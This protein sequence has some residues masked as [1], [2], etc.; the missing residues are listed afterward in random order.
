MSSSRVSKHKKQSKSKHTADYSTD[1]ESVSDTASHLGDADEYD[2][3]GGFIVKDDS[4]SDVDMNTDDDYDRYDKMTEEEKKEYDKKL[5]DK[6]KKEDEEFV[7]ENMKN[8]IPGGRSTRTRRAPKT[9]EDEYNEILD[10]IKENTEEIN[11]LQKDL[12]EFKGRLTNEGKKEKEDVKK[13]INIVKERLEL[14]K[15]KRDI[16]EENSRVY[17][18][19]DDDDDEDN[20]DSEMSESTSSSHTSDDDYTDNDDE[21]DDY[22]VE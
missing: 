18:E 13:A 19:S 14:L 6:I 2:S 17:Y 7:T 15:H 22:D 3:D 9:A 21:D 5:Q 20:D 11:M 16:F 10:K 8:I 1:E 4:C 12:A